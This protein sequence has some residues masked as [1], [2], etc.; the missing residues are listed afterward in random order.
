MRKLLFLSRIGFL[1]NICFLI[2]WLLRYIPFIANGIVPSTIIIMG[3]VLAI[4]INLLLIILYIVLALA[5]KSFRQY[6]PNWLIIVNFM[7]FI[8]QVILLIK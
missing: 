8:F 6:V 5:G 1:C 7:F 2:S 3:H 4:V